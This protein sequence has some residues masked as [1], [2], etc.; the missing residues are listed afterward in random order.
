MDKTERAMRD[1]NIRGEKLTGWQEPDAGVC[2][3]TNAAGENHIT[4]LAF[5]LNNLDG[6]LPDMSPLVEL[7][8]LSACGNN[9][10]GAFPAFPPSIKTL[11]MYTNHMSGEIPAAISALTNM[12]FMSL[13]DN[14]FTGPAPDLSALSSMT[15]VYL[16]CNHLS[17][18]VTN[19]TDWG[20]YT[21]KCFLDASTLLEK[22]SKPT[23]NTFSCPLPANAK[24]TCHAT[25]K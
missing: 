22:C 23:D 6:P 16:D 2:C 18:A 19:A 13:G 1:A 20:S 21:G 12:K 24:K 17:G 15:D 3:K 11:R 4:Q 8:N 7:D 14:D 5:A 9:I 10:T 25:C